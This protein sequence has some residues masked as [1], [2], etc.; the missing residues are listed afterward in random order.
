VTDDAA[1]RDVMAKAR[2]LLAGGLTGE[3]LRAKPDL[4]AIM[5]AEFE[6]IEKKL[7][8]LVINKGTRRYRDEEAA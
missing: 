6:V 7:D 8:G 1:L 3:D 5:R 2:A 4:R